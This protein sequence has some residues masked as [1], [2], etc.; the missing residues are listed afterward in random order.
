MFSEDMG[1]SHLLSLAAGVGT[2]QE[3]QSRERVDKNKE[4]A[5]WV[6]E[7]NRERASNREGK[8]GKGSRT[9]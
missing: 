8:V 3:S 1:S 2:S 6:K 9:R 7:R 4:R 5:Q